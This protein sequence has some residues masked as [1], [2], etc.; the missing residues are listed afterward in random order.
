MYSQIIGTQQIVVTAI[1]LGIMLVVLIVLRRNG[2]AIRASLKAGK[3]IAVIEDT[4]VS[5]TERLRLISVDD[6]KFLMLSAKGQAPV[7][8]PFT[9]PPAVRPKP[10]RPRRWGL[11]ILMSQT[12]LH[13]RNLL[14]KLV[15]T[16]C[17]QHQLNVLPLSKNFKAGDAIMRQASFLWQG[18]RGWGWLVVAFAG[19]C[20]MGVSPAFA[21]DS[22]PEVMNGLAAGLPALMANDAADGSTSYSLSLQILALMTALT[23]LP[24]LVLG[25]TSF[26]RIII[27]LSLLRQAMG[28]Q[29]TPPNQVLI[30]IALFLTFFIMSPTLTSVYEKAGDPYLN[31]QIGAEAALDMA[32]T[33]MKEFMVKNTRKNDLTMFMD[34]G[35]NGAVNAPADVPLSALLPAFITSELKTAF[36]IGFLLFLPFLVIDMVVASVLMSLGMMMLSPMLVAMPFKLLLFVLVDGWTMTVGSLVATYVV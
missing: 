30:A 16:R 3:R 4:A 13:P 17:I 8:M 12:R 35:E 25:M 20:L 36:Q 7:L 32:T 2:G 6:S 29:Q 21:Q 34:L 22:V 28:T 5:P 24:S 19:V 14:Y 11:P 1:F 15:A 18:I 31:G 23:V 9:T 10:L 33:E 27:V 26:T